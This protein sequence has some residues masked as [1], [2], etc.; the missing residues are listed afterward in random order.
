MCVLMH[1]PS[2]PSPAQPELGANEGP[3]GLVVAPTRE[4]AQQI[5]KE[6]KK[7]GKAYGLRV[8]AICG[9][10]SMWEQ[11]KVCERLALFFASFPLFMWLVRWCFK[12]FFC[13]YFSAVR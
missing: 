2:Y 4:L 3:I 11:R 10:E 6:A 1:P 5:F 8:V 9:G 7:F 12:C 13:L